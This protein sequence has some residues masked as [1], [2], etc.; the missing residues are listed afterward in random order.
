MALGI[1]VA[2]VL[3]LAGGVSP[4]GGESVGGS[5]AGAGDGDDACFEEPTPNMRSRNEGLCFFLFVGGV[6]AI[7]LF[8]G[9]ISVSLPVFGVGASLT[10]VMEMMLTTSHSSSPSSSSSSSSS[11]TLLLLL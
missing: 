3:C 8:A 5:L 4:D 7:V 6:G 1:G 10:G 11:F 2:G 9:V